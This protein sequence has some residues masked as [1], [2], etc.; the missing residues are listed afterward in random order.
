METKICVKKS[1]VS[2]ACTAGP[3]EV[4]P[5]SEPPSITTDTCNARLVSND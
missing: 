1:V 4:Q 5:A 2:A 3:V